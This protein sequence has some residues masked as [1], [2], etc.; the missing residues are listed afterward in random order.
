MLVAGIEPATSSLPWMRSTDWAKPAVPIYYIMEIG[1]LS[2]SWL[3]FLPNIL[4]SWGH[5]E[6][7][8]PFA[9][10]HAGLSSRRA[11]RENISSLIWPS[12]VQKLG[13][14]DH[15]QQWACLSLTVQ[16]PRQWLLGS[17]C[18][19]TLVPIVFIQNIADT[20]LLQTKIQSSKSIVPIIFLFSFE[21]DP[22]FSKWAS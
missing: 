3:I 20:P 17:L 6:L 22:P 8:L 4:P 9:L 21:L 7:S 19:K 12:P 16:K 15:E 1:L 18:R 14:P 2:I 10:L 13:C 11:P 5:N